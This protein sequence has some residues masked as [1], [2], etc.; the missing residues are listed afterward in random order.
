MNREKPQYETIADNLID[1]IAV[2]HY[3]IGENI[4]TEHQLC[5]MF[6]VSRFTI[7]H[8][9]EKLER[10][11]MVSR[12][13]RRGTQ[14]ISRFPIESLA[15]KGGILQEWV[16][17]GRE[18]VL[19]IETVQEIVPSPK[20]IGGRANRQKWL[21]LFGVRK[22]KGMSLPACTSEIWVHPSY[23][24]VRERII[25]RPAMIFTLIEEKY[26]PLIM[27]VRHELTAVPISKSLAHCLKVEP[28]SPGLQ[29]VRRYLGANDQLVEMVINTHPHDRFTYSI[30]VQRSIR[31]PKGTQQK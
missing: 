27:R 2:G 14:V 11:G 5:A 20:L 1:T 7:A 9:L 29:T 6:C 15:E 25:D 23:K 21:Y 3:A 16:G 26:G 22:A 17:Y 12:K 31:L 13:P 30:E 19:K 4:P 24:G 8:A 28:G 18:F 10:L